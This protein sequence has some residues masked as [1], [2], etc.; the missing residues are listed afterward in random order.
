MSKNNIINMSK[1]WTQLLPLKQ[2]FDKISKEFSQLWR[3]RRLFHD[4]KRWE[5]WYTRIYKL[6]WK[7][8]SSRFRRY[9]WAFIFFLIF[10]FQKCS[11]KER[12]IHQLQALWQSAYLGKWLVWLTLMKNTAIYLGKFWSM[13][14][15]ISQKMA[16][17]WLRLM[18]EHS[19][20]V[21]YKKINIV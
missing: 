3:R 7:S 14:L 13:K 20:K 2:N 18:K 4:D 10:H 6:P 1:S 21:L 17:L 19:R 16:F 9:L 12:V 11:L 8:T 5:K 15:L